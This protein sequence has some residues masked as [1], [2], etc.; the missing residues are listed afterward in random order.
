MTDRRIAQR[1]SVLAT[2]EESKLGALFLTSD[3][4]V[5]G[6]ALLLLLAS[7]HQPDDSTLAAIAAET[8]K[9]T[10]PTS[11]WGRSTD[12]I[13]L[14]VQAPVAEGAQGCT[15]EQV[16]KRRDKLELGHILRAA[17]AIA[18]G[19]AALGSADQRHLDI[20][21]ARVW[22]PS[23]SLS[24][25]SPLLFGTGWWRLMPAYQAN[26]AADAFYGNPEF[27]AAELCKGQAATFS[28]D[29]YGAATTVWALAAG[30]PPFPSNQPLMALK[31]QAVERPL[32]LD[33][34]KPALS[35]IKDLQALLADA[36]DKDPAKRPA[37]ASWRTAVEAL[38]TQKA[39]E[40][41]ER[42]ALAPA[43]APARMEPVRTEPS[44]LSVPA[45]TGETMKFSVDAVA[46]AMA[47]GAAPLAS[48]T[49]PPEQTLAAGG[50]TSEPAAPLPTDLPHAAPAEV[51]DGA[52]LDSLPT[53]APAGEDDIDLEVGDGESED[54]SDGASR[55]GKRRRERRERQTV[56]GIGIAAALA[57]RNLAE[58]SSGTGSAPTLI[59]LK[60]DSKIV[61]ILDGGMLRGAEKTAVPGR[62]VSGS[63]TSPVTPVAKRAESGSSPKVVVKGQQPS[64]AAMGMTDRVR[65]EIAQGA[66]F[67]EDASDLDP[68]ELAESSPPTPHPE[69]VNRKAL[70]SILGFGAVMIGL[71]T[72][73]SLRTPAPEPPKPAP[74]PMAE[75]PAEPE[76]DVVAVP[77]DASAAA[78]VPEAV[79]PVEA[80]P[81]VDAVAASPEPPADA[82]AAPPLAIA[83][84]A[85]PPEP[86]PAPNAPAAVPPKPVEVPAVALAPVA[87]T[88]SVRRAQ[89]QKLLDQGRS[90]LATKD[91]V[92][93]MARAQEALSLD[94]GSAPA[95][96]LREE[97]ARAVHV[98]TAQAKADEAKQ[99]AENAAREK[100]EAAKAKAVSDQ[101]AKQEAAARAAAEQAEAKQAAADKLAAKADAARRAKDF[102]AT[103]A[104]AAKAAAEA[105][106]REKQERAAAKAAR[107]SARAAAE[108]SQRAESTAT[109]QRP[110]AAAPKAA[111][112]RAEAPAADASGSADAAKFAA[113]AQ[114]ASKAKLKVLYLQKALKLD[115]SNAAYKGQLKAAEEQLKSEAP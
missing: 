68:K 94:A 110:A 30:K 29:V 22:L 34:V 80:A 61:P 81:T 71:S 89:V 86:V 9:D 67:E 53:S 92:T 54:S 83:A 106:A 96:L 78:A 101:I 28:T 52:V 11:A 100:A 49:P 57:E 95:A 3:D 5:G 45:N 70:F 55:S 84:P 108:S 65:A 14:A 10:L 20:Q 23:G 88:D 76:P 85:A 72:W 35:G 103:R 46:K 59:G 82:A 8:A 75:A 17:V 114:K 107:K 15:L 74:A 56:A 2:L 26:S 66:F 112:P 1:F 40:A 113:L 13:W 102:A 90:A 48:P 63:V 25:G 4:E 111:A 36:L 97:A 51:A 37:P 7:S 27:L 77:E 60:P 21:P 98:A 50:V 64:N 33:L 24:G 16:I 47:E 109:S 31:R 104:S 79:T 41:L 18:R 99:A 91:P 6:H 39:P 93:A 38:A 58:Q 115:P 73:M 42:T 62:P 43:A 69:Q 87:A 32:R 44:D 12:G 105:K 19:V